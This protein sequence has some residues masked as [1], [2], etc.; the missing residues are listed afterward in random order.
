MASVVDDFA[1]WL[2]NFDP[3]VCERLQTDFKFAGEL[4][5]VGDD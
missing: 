3:L 2:C 4:R 5:F 1:D